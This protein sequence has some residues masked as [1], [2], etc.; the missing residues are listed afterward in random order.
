[1]KLVFIYGPPASGKLTVARELGAITGYPVFH[2]HLV[3]DMLT[4]VFEFGSPS[5]VGLREGVWLKV[6]TKAAEEDMEG[7]IF[8]FVPERTVR[9]EFI[10]DLS[11]ALESRASETIFV[12]LKCPDEELEQRMENESRA[13]YGKLRSVF[14]YRR[15]HESGAFDYPCITDTNLTIDTSSIEPTQAAEMI[16]DYIGMTRE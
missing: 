9:R 14:E 4:P 16:L 8:T 15:L 12:E 7:V 13:D 6:L 3:V 2:N 10:D 1:M 5:F 11:R